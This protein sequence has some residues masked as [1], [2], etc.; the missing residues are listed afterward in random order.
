MA[1]LCSLQS[2]PGFDDL[3]LK[4]VISEGSLDFDGWTTL[5]SKIETIYPDDM[6]KICLVYDH[7]LSQFPLCYGYWR[8]YAVHM[9][10]L[11]TVDKVVEVFE[12]AVQSAT[13][14]VEVWVD[15]CSF[16]ISAFEDPSDIR[17]LFKRAISFVGKD[18]LCH[19]LWD[20]YI[21]FEFSQK[22]W[23]SLAHIYVQALRFPT[24]KL[25]QYYDSFKKLVTLLEEDMAS[26]GYPTKESQ[27]ESLLDDD[28]SVSCKDDEIYG[29]IKYMMDSSIGLKRLT[30]MKKFKNLGE[31]LYHNAC[32]LDLKISSFEANIQR[33]YFHVK[34]LDA[35]QLQN[36][37]HYL[38]FVE[39][40]GDFDW[41]VKLYERCLIVCANYPEYWMRYVDF[42][43]TKGGREIAKYSLERA[44]EIFL[45]RVRVIHLF[46]ARFKEQIGDVSAARAAYIHGGAESDSNFVETVISKANMEKRLGNM[47][48]AFNVYKEA[49]E[50]AAADKKLHALPVLYVNYSR[51]KY[52]STNSVDAAR[53]VLIEGVKN[54]P[55]SKFLLELYYHIRASLVSL[56]QLMFHSRLIS[57][58]TSLLFL[59]PKLSIQELIKF[60]LAHG[61]PEHIAVIDSIVGGAI[62]PRPD[63]SQGLST[64][65]AEDISN[66]YL[67]FVDSCGTVHDVSK[68]W[69]RHVKLF[70][71]F[72]RTDTHQQ[73]AKCRQ[74][75][76]SVNDRGE[77]TSVAVPDALNAGV[78]SQEGPSTDPDNAVKHKLQFM[79]V[80]NTVQE[81]GR[82][83]PPT[84][85]EE[86]SH[87]DAEENVS[88]A[89]LVE[90]KEVSPEAYKNFE[91]EFSETEVFSDNLENQV[92]REKEMLP[93]S[94]S[95]SKENKAYGQEMYEVESKEEEQ[96]SL[97]NRSLNPQK[98]TCS[99]SVPMASH[100][101]ESIPEICKSNDG[102]RTG[103]SNA[104]Q[105]SSASAQDFE[106]AQTP[107]EIN[108]PSSSGRHHDQSARRS[109]LPPRSNRNDGNWHQMRNAG[110]VHRGPKYGLRRQGYRKQHQRHE[111]SPKRSHPPAGSFQMSTSYPSQPA[112]QIQQGSQGQNQFQSSAA[113]DFAAAHS[114]PMQNVPLQ[115][116]ASQSQ[117]PVAHAT[118][119][120]MQGPEQ[121][122]N[123]QNAQ[124]YDQMWQYYYYHHQQFVQQ[125][126]QQ[127]Q[128]QQALML[129]QQYQQ[130][131]QLQQ[132][133]TQYQQPS[134]HQEQS[135]QFQQQSQPE[136]LQSQQSQQ[137][138]LLQPEPQLQQQYQ[139]QQQQP[140][141]QELPVY[142]QQLLPSSQVQQ[143][144][145]EQIQHDQSTPSLHSQ[146][147]DYS[148]HQQGPG[149]KLVSSPVPSEKSSQGE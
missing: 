92:A 70:P 138:V 44:T 35:S 54:M 135:Q 9:N 143:T 133:Y 52:M 43:E 82:E 106:S 85:F 24:K 28:I 58:T 93:T 21:H 18:Y 97:E 8:K 80:D 30:A 13:F 129:Q 56:L 128:P 137:Q 117:P 51:L 91:K 79:G 81:K 67:E 105:G 112:L 83:L 130:Q 38:D 72:A 47:E 46:D 2:T 102:L 121:Y 111:Q 77:E 4:E 101:C 50:M 145:Q 6:E 124:A 53:D 90:V 147:L 22:Q 86:Q 69:N 32:Q 65:D 39:L 26:Q 41:A 19:T 25:H 126:Q 60:S 12:Q 100:D 29:I 98:S 123:M 95:Y 16:C 66:L 134:F 103:S 142:P 33:S 119:N 140:L 113:P 3:E 68:A 114:W 20:K 149:A 139:L 61:V 75:L 23:I 55:E 34:P 120:A 148:Q 73:S 7:F 1:E 144:D 48:A 74:L 127:M 76:D 49:L 40:Q 110:K 59:E 107:F 115:N 131:F 63:G 5:I 17:R 141:Q 118:L 136:H 104:N 15:Y 125:Q 27:S 11:G 14:S 84:V 132:Q 88:S 36:W 116:P 42:M 10:H 31:Q 62:S 109:F 108:Y 99:D 89:V 71:G 57:A 87:N 146:S 94:Q 45:K 122:G 64:K 37:H 78:A 96:F